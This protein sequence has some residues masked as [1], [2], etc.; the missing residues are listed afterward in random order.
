MKI[1]ATIAIDEKLL[2][3]IDYLA[4]RQGRSRSNCIEVIL[5]EKL[6]EI[7]SHGDSSRT[8]KTGV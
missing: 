3:E 4:T 1:R 2:Y 6:K 7:T 5:R 8:D